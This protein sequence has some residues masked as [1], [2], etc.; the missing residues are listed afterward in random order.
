MRWGGSG[1]GNDDES[2][3]PIMVVIGTIDMFCGAVEYVIKDCNLLQS[4][5]SG[6]NDVYLFLFSYVDD[7]ARFMDRIH[8]L[9]V[10]T[11]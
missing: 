9:L 4:E 1:K 10:T 5:I 3:R 8:F 11:M 6:L 2:G 7:I